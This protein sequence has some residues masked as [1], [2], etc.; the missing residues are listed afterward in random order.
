MVAGRYR[1]R[2]IA[3]Q[4]L[5]GRLAMMVLAPL[6]LGAQL[7]LV[8]DRPPQLDI[9]STCRAASRAGLNGR[10]HETCMNEEN[11]AH[12]ALGNKWK[13]FTAAQQT[14]CTG[15][16]RM[17]GPPSY[18]ELLTCLEM[19]E[20]ARKIPDSD[21]LKPPGSGSAIQRD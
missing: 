1:A 15:L 11:E 10:T 9:D 2:Q 16:V 6:V 20:Q 13:D 5:H 12:R 4:R 21:A 19:A 8:A 14:R 18:V 3:P 7:I 17:G